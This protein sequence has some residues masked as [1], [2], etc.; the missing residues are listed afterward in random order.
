MPCWVLES[1]RHIRLGWPKDGHTGVNNEQGDQAGQRGAAWWRWPGW[2]SEALGT[3]LK[4]Q[5]WMRLPSEN[6]QAMWEQKPTKVG[7]WIKTVFQVEQRKQ[8]RQEKNRSYNNPI[9]SPYCP[10]TSWKEWF[11]FLNSKVTQSILNIKQNYTR[12]PWWGQEFASPGCLSELY[13]PAIW[14]WWLIFSRKWM[15]NHVPAIQ[16]W[17]EMFSAQYTQ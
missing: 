12:S 7:A 5:V 8:A 15:Y 13:P 2:G 16:M 1:L 3:D 6:M 11:F 10:W 9:L 17:K 14:N 4:L